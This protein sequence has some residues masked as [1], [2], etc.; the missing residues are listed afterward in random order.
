MSRF[1]EGLSEEQ[2]NRKAQ[3]PMLKDTPLTE[4]PT[5]ATWLAM[6]GSMEGN[7]LEFHTNHM[8]EILRELGVPGK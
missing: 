4:Y 5:L 1:A 8:R 6:L 3:V 7:H 2:L